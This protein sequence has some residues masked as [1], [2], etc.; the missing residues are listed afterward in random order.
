M[1]FRIE[2]AECL[3]LLFRGHARPFRLGPDRRVQTLSNPL[4]SV[5][6]FGNSVSC[7]LEGKH[8]IGGFVQQLPY[9]VEVEVELA[10]GEDPLQAT[11]VG[12]GVSA[13]A[14]P[15]ALGWRE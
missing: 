1:L 6:L 9:L 12:A 15:S 2:I 7:L 3:E 14:V 8:G 13:V 10:V 11:D 4:Q 5:N